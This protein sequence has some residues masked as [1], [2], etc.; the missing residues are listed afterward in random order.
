MAVAFVLASSNWAKRPL[1]YILVF[2]LSPSALHQSS[3]PSVMLVLL[4]LRKIPLVYLYH[5]PRFAVHYWGVSSLFGAGQDAPPTEK[6]NGMI[7]TSYTTSIKRNGI[8]STVCGCPQPQH[9]RR[10]GLSG[11]GVF[12]V[13]V[14]PE[15][16]HNLFD[17][18]QSKSHAIP[19]R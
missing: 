9:K 10:P 1:D 13:N 19:F 16:C 12:K 2:S 15:I 7:Q 14:A 17:D 6:V 11:S 5:F 4:V 8:S 18:C 3:V